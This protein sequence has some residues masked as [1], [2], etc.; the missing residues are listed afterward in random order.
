MARK[1]FDYIGTIYSEFTEKKGMP[2]QG[3]LSR[4]S[5]GIVEVFPEYSAGLKDIDGFSHIY[6]IY[7]FHKSEGYSLITKPFLEDCNHGVFAT[8]APKRPNPIGISI[9]SIDQ[10]VDNTIYVAE[11]DIL[12]GTPLLDI[13]P[14][15]KFFDYRDNT[16]DG[17]ISTS[18]NKEERHYSDERFD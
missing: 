14:Y 8:R 3:A 5:K 12:N 1:T 7:E 4:D 6:L 18:I 15:V 9:V 2:I 17:W 13:K 16:R 10:V 11:M